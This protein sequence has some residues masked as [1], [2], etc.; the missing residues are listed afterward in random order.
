MQFATTR[1][2]LAAACVLAASSVAAQEYPD[3]PIRF[4]VP[5]APGGTNDIVARLSGAKLAESLGQ[6]VVVDNRGGANAAIGTEIAARA[7]PDGYTLLVVNINFAINPAM[8]GALPYDAL[9]D[10]API[11]LLAV[12]PTVLVVHPSQPIAS[13]QELVAY[14]K[15][16]PGKLNYSTSG[17]GSS[18]HIP[19][20]LLVSM[21]GM[22][23]VPIHY[24]GG[25]PALLDLLSG[26]VP[27]G[28]TTILSVQPHL[29][30]NRL[31]AL[32]VSSLR[33]SPSLPGVP[34]VAESG[35][36]GYEF[37]GWWGVVAPSKTPPDVVRRLNGEFVKIQ[38]APYMT[39]H[40]NREGAEPRTTTPGE[41]TKFLRAETLKWGKVARDNQL[42]M[43]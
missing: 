43:E 30:A 8:M 23:M 29:K 32:A 31:R 25:G 24:K 33:R 5:F 20:E 14:A 26:R 36:P 16:N 35:V 9:R 28:F 3:R 12:S 11:S 15:A 19:M 21:T 37:V 39:E 17:S 2:I 40:L 34:T 13:V 7:L 22:Q 41:F 4:I 18:T 10:F 27:L 42:H 6:S 38:H 1:R